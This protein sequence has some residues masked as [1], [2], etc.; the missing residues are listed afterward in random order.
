LTKNTQTAHILIALLVGY[1][2]STENLMLEQSAEAGK[3][4]IAQKSHHFLA[5]TIFYASLSA[6]F[7]HWNLL[8]LSGLFYFNHLNKIFRNAHHINASFTSRSYN[9]ISFGYEISQS[10]FGSILWHKNSS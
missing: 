1:P 6:I 9:D 5:K 3:I 7:K 4:I 8:K 2:K 10:I